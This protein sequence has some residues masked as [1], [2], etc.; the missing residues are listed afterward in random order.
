MSMNSV[1]AIVGI[2]GMVFFVAFAWLIVQY[3]L[4]SLSI[5]TVAKRRGVANAGLAWVPVVW[6]W[7]L[8]GVCDQYDG[9]HGFRRK[10]RTVL[11]TLSIVVAAAGVFAYILLFAQAARVAAFTQYNHYYYDEEEIIRTVFGAFAGS[12]VLL[13]IAAVVA[14]VLGICQSICL[15]KFYE[16]CRPNDAVKLLLLSLL[17]PFAE[18]FCLLSCRNYDLGMPQPQ[19]YAPQQP[20]QPQYYAPQQ[21]E[22]PQ[23]YAP[24][25]PEQPQYNAPQEPANNDPQQP[26]YNPYQ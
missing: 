13:I 19:Y 18:P 1:G 26:P 2:V 12:Y 15:F 9:T 10:W 20:E 4:R 7:T 17:V 8:G 14:S 3:V 16:S 23:Y 5:Y 24:Q 21:P 22:Q 11:L 6:V 25:Q